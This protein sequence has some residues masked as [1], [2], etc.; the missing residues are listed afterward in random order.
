MKDINNCQS[1][2][3]TCIRKSISII[4]IFSIC[5]TTTAE[6]TNGISAWL[7]SGTIDWGT[8]GAETNEICAGILLSPN[9]QNNTDFDSVSVYI[10]T[11]KTN[12]FWDYLGPPNMKFARFELKDSN[13]VVAAPKWWGIKLVSELPQRITKEDLPVDRGRWKMLVNE[14]CLKAGTP[15][16]FKDFNIHDVYQIKKEGDYT[17][18]VGVAIYQ[19]APD[20]KAVSRLDL[21]CV[22]IKIHLKPSE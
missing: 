6:G 7:K 13:G 4:V 11:S 15:S 5:I 8:W 19:F 10:L 20:R 14:L 2:N 12:V 9:P 21:P 1:D 22:T 3:W 17:L 16:R 18:S